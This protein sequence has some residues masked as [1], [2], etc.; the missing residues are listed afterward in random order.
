MILLICH[1]KT[2][3]TIINVSQQEMSEALGLSRNTITGWT[4]H[5]KSPL[6]DTAY[7]VQDYING[8]AAANGLEKRWALEQIW[9][10]SQ[11]DVQNH[12]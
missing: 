10:K 12:T 2:I 7:Q 8:V 3:L 6:L 11:L 9:E 1:I 5:G 4:R